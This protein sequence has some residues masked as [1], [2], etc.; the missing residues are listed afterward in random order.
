MSPPWRDDALNDMRF[1]GMLELFHL[2]HTFH[3]FC[4][5]PPPQPLC[6]IRSHGIQRLGSLNKTHLYFLIKTEFNK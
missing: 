1:K 3:D 5:P 2:N 6:I 4:S